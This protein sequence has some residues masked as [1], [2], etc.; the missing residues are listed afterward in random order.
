M[1][2]IYESKFF[3]DQY[4]IFLN[5]D[6][7]IKRKRSFNAI[8]SLLAVFAILLSGIA[9]NGALFKQVTGTLFP[10]AYAFVYRG[11]CGEEMTWSYDS[12]DGI[13]II[14]GNGD[15][16]EYDEM[17]KI[18]WYY[19]RARIH[20]IV[21]EEGVTS[22]CANAFKYFSSLTSVSLPTTLKR[23]GAFAFDESKYY[24]DENN[25]HN[26]ILY[27]NR[28]LIEVDAE[29]LPKN[30]TIPED[31]LSIGTYAFSNC[32]SLTDVVIPESVQYIGEFAFSYCKNLKTISLPHAL[33]VI[34]SN[35]FAYCDSLTAVNFGEQSCVAEIEEGAFR[36]CKS[37]AEITLPDAVTS[38]GNA[39]FENCT[40][41]SE[42]FISKNV[43]E[44]EEDVFNGCISLTTFTVDDENLAF[45]SVEG[46]LYDKEV[47][48]LLYYPSAKEVQEFAVP[49][50]VVRINSFAFYENQH[51]KRI[52]LPTTLQQI[53]AFAFYGCHALESMEI[54]SGI[55]EINSFAFS[56]CSVLNSVLIPA[57]VKR[58]NDYAFS[59]CTALTDIQLP[60]SVEYVASEAF[61]DTA[62]FGNPD[63]LIDGVL[64]LGNHLLFADSEQVAGVY[65]VREN[66]KTISPFAFLNC[67]N[68]TAVQ[69]PDSVEYI[70]EQAFFGC[71][72][73][74]EID[75]SENLKQ[76]GFSVFAETAYY[77][78]PE[79]WI[80]G[81]LYVADCLVKADPVNCVGVFDVPGHVT[82][83]AEQ[84][85]SG[86]ENLTGMDLPYGLETVPAAAFYDCKALQTVF[87]PITVKHIEESAFFGCEALECVQFQQYMETVET[88]AF[89]NCTSLR[90]IYFPVGMKRIAPLAFSGCTALQAVHFGS[91]E[92]NWTALAV[93]YGNDPLLQAEMHYYSAFDA[94]MRGDIDCNRVIDSSDA[95]LALRLA[96]GLETFDEYRTTAA[97]IDLDGAITSTD[98][99][100][101]LRRSVSLPDWVWDEIVMPIL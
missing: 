31:L 76:I 68:L 67:I 86:C 1:F 32:S 43:E 70:G 94:F 73:L 61:I 101:I 10:S 55:T 49:E 66:T 36:G 42:I 8:L 50:S 20:T 23:V 47:Q 99:R 19:Y 97:D 54:P 4:I 98:A 27:I 75:M 24:K 11:T 5:G 72:H 62:F 80:E 60:D 29:K 48:T 90:E 74:N 17:H 2:S 79:N 85:F 64:Y 35:T 63:N 40:A 16:Y 83:I 91:N 95:R 81:V 100:Y 28:H 14:Q 45:C 37:L 71:S 93:P 59:G 52:T 78:N 53:A 51:L 18:P 13:L 38:L 33:E 3:V 26:G 69:I 39:A 30:Y 84:A 88:A 22:L 89:F 6:F 21:V 34:K 12:N 57:T 44:I 7:V 96:V 41:L 46:V 56:D 77:Q 65:T 87:F 82:C 58:I 9:G 92:K 25:W 15:M